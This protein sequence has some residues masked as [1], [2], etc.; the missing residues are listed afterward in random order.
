MFK[1]RISTCNKTQ[2]YALERLRL[3]IFPSGL[4]MKI[5]LQRNMRGQWYDY[6][7]THF[8]IHSNDPSKTILAASIKTGI[9]RN[10]KRAHFPKLNHSLNNKQEGDD[11]PKS[12]I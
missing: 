5:F 4:K 3:L 6:I 1:M 2:T 9:L 8:Q 7:T 11:G 12:L 10:H